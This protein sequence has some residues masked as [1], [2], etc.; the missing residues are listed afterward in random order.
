MNKIIAKTRAIASHIVAKVNDFLERR[1]FTMKGKLVTIFLLVKVLP[2]LLLLA[3]AWTQFVGLGATIKER[4]NLLTADMNG[5]LQDVGDLAVS[6]SK[7]SLNDSAIEQIERQ[8]TDIASEVASFLYSVDADARFLASVFANQSVLQSYINQKTE[9]VVSKGTWALSEDGMEWIRTDEDKSDLPKQPS[10]N[11]ENIDVVDGSGWGYRAPDTLTYNNLPLYDE[12]SFIGTDFVEK[13]KVFPD[14]TTKKNFPMSRE[15]KDISIKANT[16]LG[17]ESYSDKLK[18]L[19]PGDIYVSDVIG[20]Y[21]PSHFIGMYTP[22]QMVISAITA[23]I[24][25]LD[26]LP[27]EEQTDETAK[28]SKKLTTLKT[29]DL[30]KMETTV[31]S[32]DQALMD[33]VISK[34]LPLFDK[35]T[36]EITDKKLLSEVDAV[37]TKVSSLKFDPENEAYAGQE[38]P[39]GKRFEG[40][41]RWITPVSS[42]DQIT[43]YIS[44][45]LNHD[46]IMEFTDHVTPMNERYTE[47]PSAFDG[48]YAFIWDYQCRNIAHPRHHSIVGYDAV[49]G[50][51]QIP[52]L[53]T[54]IYDSLLERLGGEDLDALRDG[55]AEVTNDPQLPDT[56]YKGVFDLIKDAPVFDEQSRTKKPALPLTQN[57]LVGLDGRYLN[58][59]PQC[60][61]WM[62]LTEEGGSG[63]FY[64]LWSGIYK[65]TTAAAIPY[66][67]GQYAPSEENGFSKRG[68]AMVTI[69]AGLDDFQA[70]A[71][72]TEKKLNSAIAQ[73]NQHTTNDSIET[74]ETITKSLTST[75]IQLIVST[76]L[77]IILIVF[78]ALWMASFLTDNIRSLIR[79]LSRF[80]AG[81][82]QFRFRSERHDEF[83]ELADSFDDMAD[84]IVDSVNTPLS[85]TNNELKLIYM[86]EHALAATGHTLGEIVGKSYTDHSIYPF[87]T[88]YCP[89]TALKDGRKANVY[90][91]EN[92]SRYYRG[93]ADY[94]FDKGGEAIGYI[95]TSTDVTDS[96]LTRIELENAVNEANIANEHKGEFLARMSH[97]IRTPMNAIIGMT[98]IVEKK[99]DET[100][101]KIPEIDEIKTHMGQIENSS[102]HLLGLLNDILDLSKIDAGKIELTVENV[103]LLMLAGTVNEI[104]RPR[105]IEKK[106]ELAS[107]FDYDLKGT[108]IADALR[109]RQVLINLLGNAVKFTPEHGRIEFKMEKIDSS[110]ED[111]VEK[112]HVKFTIIDSG[113]GMSEESRDAI[114]KPF[115]QASD[116]TFKKFGGTGLGLP[117]SLNIV[118]LMGSDIEVESELDEGSTFTFSVWLDKVSAAEERLIIPDSSSVDF[119][120]KRILI[121]DDVDINRLITA[122]LLEDTGVHIDEAEDGSVALEMFSS[123]AV[124]TYDLIIMDVQMPI[125]NGLEAST[126]IRNLDREDAKT[127]PIIALTANAFKDDIDKARE[128]GMNAHLSKPIDEDRLIE[129][130]FRYISGASA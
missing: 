115:E 71:K 107:K 35:A 124:G 5:T 109:L 68:F 127:I 120:G 87:D 34:A 57:G 45:A 32:E 73:A 19:A 116:D 104:I 61:G 91:N 28:L 12:I 13:F 108:Y 81:E 20:S 9:Q 10:T 101:E 43:G 4:T 21:T 100:S 6:D 14:I 17:A 93:N 7:K 112:V 66:Y 79:G 122:A 123:S 38:N 90:F 130:L 128:A 41:V 58:N 50:N 94:L 48:N 111:G 82:R 8:T 102:Q 95:I 103:D 1:G 25:A 113:I 11:K 40:I 110:E 78:I 63:S 47:L 126:A 72:A 117:I 98:N 18:D 27:K 118:Q 114:F 26:A 56:Y 97:E 92:D 51:E 121:V 59:A 37:K 62:D 42:G 89:V 85:I 65:L 2:L 29:M 119:R 64:I 83:G 49:S 77:L 3:I 22:K 88:E 60:T 70:P 129:M 69:G 99:L 16:Y 30:P 125:M 33:E 80:R 36:D 44:I 39:N 24:T 55:W 46:H 52:W 67:T 84:S 75:T 96:A 53:E 106:I 54:S 76:L 23:E 105:C 86:N 74:D 31:T 15:L